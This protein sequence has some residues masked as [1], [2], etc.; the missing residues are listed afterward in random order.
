MLITNATIVTW[1]EPN[2]ILKDSA[3]AIQADKIIEL[4]PTKI[5]TEKYPDEINL[6]AQGA[7]VMPGNIC[8]HTHFYGAFARGMAIPGD[9]PA[10]FVE[11]LSRLWWTLDK[12]LNMEAVE[13]SALV[14]QIDAIRHG[15]T[16][17]IDHHASPNSLENSLDIIQQTAERSGI[18]AALCYEVTDRDGLQRAEQGINE[19]VRFITHLKNHPSPLVRPTFGLHASLTLSDETFKKA[20]NSCPEEVGMHIHV[21][22][23]QADQ[24]DSLKKSN[25]RV[26]ERLEHFGVLGP[27]AILAHAVH[28]NDHEIELINT[29]KSWVTHQ[30]RSNMNNAVGLPRVEQMLRSGVKVCLGNDGFSNAMWEE[31]KATYL[32]HKLIH[33][34]PRRMP[35]DIVARMAIYNNSCLVSQLFDQPVGSLTP[36]AQADLILVDYEP[37]TDVNNGNLPWHIVFGFHESMIQTTIVAGKILMKDRKLLTLDEKKITSEAMG[38]SKEVWKNYQS[39]FK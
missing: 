11:I 38:L 13:Y 19:N 9:A 2:R 18:R 35:A 28:V 3:I 1:E 32:S 22:E 25:M 23:D 6:D 7:F 8:A 20:R 37:Y 39:R 10:N 31:W 16:T 26:V 4:G 30:P 33:R 12:S 24:D 27:R 15:T 17:L 5:I 36:G 21:A 34:D 29:S 14:C